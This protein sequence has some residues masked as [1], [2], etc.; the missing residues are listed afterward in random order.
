MCLI[1]TPSPSPPLHRP[2][3]LG[4]RSASSMV[5]HGS[6]LAYYSRCLPSLPSYLLVGHAG[7]LSSNNN[8]GIVSMAPHLV[9]MHC[10]SSMPAIV[11]QMCN[12]QHGSKLGIVPKSSA[13]TPT[14]CTSLNSINYSVSTSKRN[15][16]SMQAYSGPM[17]IRSVACVWQ[18][19]QHE[20]G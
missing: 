17:L 19:V 20:E 16:R 13:S 6:C 5:R 10:D 15:A 1:D 11:H 14:C 4:W 7:V 12:V 8:T 3:P 9:S 18:T 2:A